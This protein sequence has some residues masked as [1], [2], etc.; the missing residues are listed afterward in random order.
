MISTFRALR[1]Y[2]LAPEVQNALVDN[3]TIMQNTR[4]ILAKLLSRE[5]RYATYVKTIL[6]FLCNLTIYATNKVK[7]LHLLGPV[8]VD[9]LKHPD[10]DYVS[11]ALLYNIIKD[12]DV[13]LKFIHLD[14]YSII[15]EMYAKGGDKNEYLG[16]IVELFLNNK[17]FYSN[18]RIYDTEKRLAILLA[19]KDCVS[20]E[21][22]KVDGELVDILVH[23]FKIK[24][25]C[26]LK[27]VAD[28]LDD[29]EPLEVA[30]LLEILASLSG[31]E[32]CLPYLQND[33]SLLINC[34]FLLRGTH[35]VGKSSLNN[36]TLIQNLNDIT[37]PGKAIRQHPAF[38]FKAALVRILGNLCWKHR[39][40]Q[41]EVSVF[42][43]I[44]PSLCNS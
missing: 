36:F 43:A 27:T 24:S 3:E 29:I 22:F 7:L 8:L 11:S 9:V 37:R 4:Y 39:G 2:T 42:A 44:A 18:Y 15:L 34:A 6:Q 25:D 17:N 5:M 41:D 40:N 23:E 10:F 13:D 12:A 26:I 21:A 35:S 30:Y 19:L 28:Y 33:K 38:G 20:K 31:N 1:N 16:F 32:I 14:I